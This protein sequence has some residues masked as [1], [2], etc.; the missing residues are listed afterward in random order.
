MGC[1]ASKGKAD[2]QADAEI[3]FKH[4]GIWGMD[5]FFGQCKDLL[6]SFAGIVDPMAAQK[7]SYLS[8]T[9]FFE[10]PGGSKLIPLV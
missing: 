9:G 7:D 2:N 4:V 8:T 6:N 1:G 5:D 3:A 10:T